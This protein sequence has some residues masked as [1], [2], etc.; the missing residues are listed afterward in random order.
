MVGKHLQHTSFIAQPD[1]DRSIDY[2]YDAP[3]TLPGTLSIPKD[4]EP[5]VI[6]LIDYNSD[7]A[8]RFEVEQPEDCA[9]YLDTDSVSWVDV[10]GLGSEDILIR[11][12]RVFGL[13]PLVLEDVVNVP[14]RPKV[15]E[16]GDQ[17][18][19][20]ARM[21]VLKESGSGF[22]SEQVSFILGKH[23]LL[24]VQEE[25]EHDCFHMVRDRIR[26]AKGTICKR[27]ADYLAYALLDAI[28][29][30]FFPILEVYGE[31]IE[32]LE[33]EVVAS[34]TRQT[35]EKIHAL[36]RELLTLRRS[37][38]PLRD[39]INSLVRDSSPE[40]VNDD[41]RIYLRDCYDH[42]VQVLDMVETYRELAASLMDVYLS[43][44]SNRM[45]EIMKVL[46]VISTIFIPLTFVAGVYGMN[47]NPEKSPLN[48]P[49]LNWYWGYPV[50]L[51]VMIAIAVSLVLFFKRKGWFEDF[52]TT[53][54]K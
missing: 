32:E 12:G 21:V 27:G 4:A 45:N 20:I 52:S 34:P 41:V 28:I 40:L 13:H 35:L 33:D 51:A 24:T 11:I 5:P 44:V 50:C 49:E 22:Y 17:I 25:P 15:E 1:D 16:Y 9:R 2:H 43:S 48:M 7:S 26:S 3:G 23:Y 37:I 36:K 53:I 38:W 10:K 30:G 19:I 39:A 46:T 31:E 8:V 29:D 54:K 47:F 18:L 42:T 14:Q 6:V